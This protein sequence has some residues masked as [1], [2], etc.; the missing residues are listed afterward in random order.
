M[1]TM[2]NDEAFPGTIASFPTLSIITPSF[3]Q[4]T[5]LPQTLDSVLKQKY[6]KLEYIVI[7]GGSTD[8]SREIIESYSDRLT[9]WVSEKDRGQVHALN[10]GLQ[11]ATGDWVGWQNSDDFYL[12][13]AFESFA[14]ATQRYPDADIVVADIVLVDEAGTPI[15]DV[16]YVKPTYES[17]FAEGMLL[18]NQAAFWRRA[19][20]ERVGFLDERY[21][22]SFDYDWFIRLL[23]CGRAV[24]V[25]EHWGCLRYH[26]QSKTSVLAEHFAK[27]NLAIRG[28]HAPSGLSVAYSQLRRLALTLARGDIGYVMRGL[29]R[30]TG[31]K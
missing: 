29:R 27:E 11:R 6:P 30:R 26:D 5:F 7:D 3:N 19:L 9:F 1:M 13:G 10:K 20:H 8:G 31:G 16:R 21:N 4:A 17:V 22:C 15:R 25:R 24:H 14:V 12:P 18:A 2:T 28:G 23:K